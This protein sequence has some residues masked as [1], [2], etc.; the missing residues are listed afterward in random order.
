[1]TTTEY[2]MVVGVF[3]DHARAAQAID[4]LHKVGFRDDKIRVGQ[5]ATASAL[6]DGLACRWPAFGVEGRTLPEELVSKG[7]PQDEAD[8]YVNEFEAGHSVVIVESSGYQREVRDILQRYGAYDASRTE[9]GQEQ[10]MPGHNSDASETGK[11]QAMSG[12]N[13]DERLEGEHTI[14]VREEVL[15]AHKKWVEIGDVIL[16]KKVITEEKTFTVPI[17]R[18][19]LIVERRPARAEFSDQPVQEGE[20]QNI[21]LEPGET[22]RII[23]HEEEVRIEKYPVVSEEILV[24]KRQIEETRAISDKLKRE[25]IHIERVGKVPLSE[26]RSDATK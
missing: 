5:G 4:E 14:P 22:F 2:P 1:M 20:M 19:E 17:T 15:Q 24:S 23:L 10:A 9:I 7:M 13:S 8:Y 3:Q 21:A 6:L 12:Q 25:E 26:K 11:E 18:E 16:R